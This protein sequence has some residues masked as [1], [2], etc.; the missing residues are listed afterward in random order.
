MVTEYEPSLPP[1]IYVFFLNKVVQFHPMGSFKQTQLE[2]PSVHS[3][4]GRILQSVH[5]IHIFLDMTR[6]QRQGLSSKSSS[7][8]LH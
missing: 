2:L 8:V 4:R 6:Q 3:P 7:S 1:A 5:W